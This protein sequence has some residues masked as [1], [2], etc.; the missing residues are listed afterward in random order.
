MEPLPGR[1][2]LS[3]P[4]VDELQFVREVWLGRIFNRKQIV[5]RWARLRRLQ[6]QNAFAL[7]RHLCCCS[8]AGFAARACGRE[9][10]WERR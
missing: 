9:D 2:V 4:D 7:R 3:A 10:A 1:V 6:G 8:Q 5:S